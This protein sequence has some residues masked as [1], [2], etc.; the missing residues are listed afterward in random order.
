VETVGL[1]GVLKKPSRSFRASCAPLPFFHTVCVARCPFFTPP[2][3]PLTRFF[4]ESGRSLLLP[5][6]RRVL[7]SVALGE[8]YGA[9]RLSGAGLG[10]LFHASHSSAGPVTWLVYVF[11][12]GVAGVLLSSLGCR[13]GMLFAIEGRSV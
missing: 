5:G 11:S 13:W 1:K 9:A 4:F 6:R 12:L 2:S 3:L 10:L 7:P 8:E